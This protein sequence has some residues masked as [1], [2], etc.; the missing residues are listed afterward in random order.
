MARDFIFPE[1]TGTWPCGTCQGGDNVATPKSTYL[2]M[3]AITPSN[4]GRICPLSIGLVCSLGRLIFAR[5]GTL[6]R[7]TCHVAPIAQRCRLS[8]FRRFGAS[9]G[10]Y[11]VPI[12]PTVRAPDDKMLKQ[13]HR[14][15]GKHIGPTFISD[16]PEES[17]YHNTFN[18]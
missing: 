8:S 14:Q 12:R 5:V 17:F 9:G 18:D 2:P 7:G 13:T 3:D 16:L 15:T 4:L 11:P 10:A 1:I 6:V